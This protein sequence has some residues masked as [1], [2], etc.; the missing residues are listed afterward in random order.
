MCESLKLL[1]GGGIEGQAI[2]VVAA[3]TFL[4]PPLDPSAI[5]VIIGAYVQ[6]NRIAVDFDVCTSVVLSA[7]S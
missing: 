6:I 5:V 1:R 2:Q 7:D 3:N 4:A